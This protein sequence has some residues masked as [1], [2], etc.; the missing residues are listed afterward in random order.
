VERS[1][2]AAEETAIHSRGLAANGNPAFGRGAI[3][4]AAV[5]L[6]GDEDA[7]R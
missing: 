4:A 1:R 6:A 7:S 5:P 2:N 3:F